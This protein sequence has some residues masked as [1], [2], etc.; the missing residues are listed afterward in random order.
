MPPEPGIAYVSLCFDDAYSIQHD[1]FYK[2]LLEHELKA[3]FYVITSRIGTR[4]RL[5][6]SQ[7]DELF[8]EGYEI[9]SHTH[10]HPHLTEISTQEAEYELQRSAELLKPFNCR[11]L[12]YP[13]G[14]YDANVVRSAEEHYFAAR[15]YYD[16]SKRSRDF[17]FNLGL[18]GEL[19][20]LKAI[21]TET[22]TPTLDEPLLMLRPSQFQ[23]AIKETVRGASEQGA[24][25]ILVFHGLNG[26]SYRLKWI[27]ELASKF[28]WMCRYLA[29]NSDVR[30][31]TL[32]D[33][34][35][36]YSG[37]SLRTLERRHRKR[38]WHST[39]DLT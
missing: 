38:T 19:H 27:L 5:T 28:H 18:P 14:E 4:G 36:L 31:L 33:A 21:P 17:G 22:A 6:R 34:A 10:T 16:L 20:K 25:M 32:F 2:A 37:R 26:I 35:R 7:L 29:N 30:V 3:S 15:S 24:W 11:T 23:K 8:E 12:A 13:Y 1:T 39:F 9:G